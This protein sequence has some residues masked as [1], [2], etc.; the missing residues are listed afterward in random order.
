MKQK[1]IH[2]K[3]IRCGFQTRRVWSLNRC[4]CDHACSHGPYGNCS[5]CG[6]KLYETVSLRQLREKERRPANTPLHLIPAEADS[7][8]I[9]EQT[10]VGIEGEVG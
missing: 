1:Y 4:D 9:G 7:S 5:R 3:C 8:T 6:S 2:V 10:Q